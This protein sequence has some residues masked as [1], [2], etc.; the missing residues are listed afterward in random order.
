[1]AFA[2]VWDAISEEKVPEPRMLSHFSNEFFRARKNSMPNF[3]MSVMDP[4]ECWKALQ[5]PLQI[6]DKV[7]PEAA[8]WV[9]DRQEHGLIEYSKVDNGCYATYHVGDRRMVLYPCFF[10]R[11][12][13]EK[14]CT[15]AHE[16]RHSR[17]GW[18]K[19]LKRAVAYL[20]LGR[21]VEWIV[22]ND[23]YY[24]EYKVREAIWSDLHF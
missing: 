24:Y 5:S 3:D 23:A 2:F 12:D 17:Q 10:L 13:G 22:E 21:K 4:D 16:Y 8:A 18:P 7:V 9:R 1:M 14:A 15:L 11:K 19:L 20:I 6:L